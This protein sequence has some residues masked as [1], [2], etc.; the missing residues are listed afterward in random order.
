MLN[1]TEDDGSS[2]LASPPTGGSNLA[3][4]GDGAYTGGGGVYMGHNNNPEFLNN[5]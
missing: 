1:L 3:V 5:R 4:P 2:L